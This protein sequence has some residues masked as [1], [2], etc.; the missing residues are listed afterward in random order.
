MYS[1]RLWRQNTVVSL[2]LYVSYLIQFILLSFLVELRTVSG[3]LLGYNL[4]GTSTRTPR[5]LMSSEKYP[6][7]YYSSASTS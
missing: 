2:I 7:L 1:S 4:P 5:L 3:N 6:V